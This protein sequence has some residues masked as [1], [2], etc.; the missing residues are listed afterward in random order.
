MKRKLQ[1]EET[2]IRFSIDLG[3][4]EMRSGAA[5]LFFLRKKENRDKKEKQR[6]EMSSPSS[7][8]HRNKRR[9]NERTLNKKRR[10]T[11][12][13][14]GKKRAKR[15]VGLDGRERCVRFGDRSMRIKKSFPSHRRSFCARHQCDTKAVDPATPRYQSCLAWDCRVASRPSSSKRRRKTKTR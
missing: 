9:S 5:L 1:S 11:C 6:D 8:K 10:K 15:I 13:K 3:K 12:S 4:K 7:R 2:F 14:G